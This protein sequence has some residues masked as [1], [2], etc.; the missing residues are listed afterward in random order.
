MLGSITIE[1]PKLVYEHMRVAE[2]HTED[3]LNSAGGGFVNH[4]LRRNTA[5]VH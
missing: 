4:F 3:S 1:T 2:I 5:R